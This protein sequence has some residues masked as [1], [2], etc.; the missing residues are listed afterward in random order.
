MPVEAGP[1]PEQQKEFASLQGCFVEGSAEQRSRERKIRRRALVLSVVVQ[2]AILTLIILIPLFGKPERIALA[3]P[4]PTAP[5]YHSNAP[6]HPDTPP[7]PN[8]PPKPSIS[9]PVFSPPSHIPDHIDETPDPT[10][11]G[12][13]GIP[14]VT[15]PTTPCSGCIPI[16]DTRPQPP[17]PSETKPK[18]PL[19][20]FTGHIEPAMLIYRVEP[21]YPALA[22]QMRLEGRV[23][24]RAVIA[25][26]GT[27][28]SLQAVSG[29][30]LFLQSA[31]AAVRQWRY[32]P[33]ILNGAPVEIDTYI[34]VVYTLQ[35]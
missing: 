21:A 24:L 1:G 15:G 16:T 26:D 19:R 4:I 3:N 25:A 18:T 5:Y 30:P 9:N 8:T 23:E 13:P 29:H 28:Q 6:S 12:V 7:K 10:P 2:S 33:T 27:I 31:I 14:I 17:S 22:R 11:P 20:I 34:T 32:R 35:K